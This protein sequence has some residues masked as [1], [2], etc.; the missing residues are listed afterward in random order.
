MYDDFNPR[1]SGDSD[2]VTDVGWDGPEPTKA[3]LD[4]FDGDFDAWY[5]A[6]Q[7][8]GENR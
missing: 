3:E 2:D 7:D 6:T 4:S 5:A 1:F 8:K